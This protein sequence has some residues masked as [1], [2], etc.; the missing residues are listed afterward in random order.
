MLTVLGPG[1]EIALAI[2]E[3]PDANIEDVL[4]AGRAKCRLKYDS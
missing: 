2:S 3:L 4:G 1:R